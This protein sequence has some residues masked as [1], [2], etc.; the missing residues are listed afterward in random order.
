MGCTLNYRFWNKTAL[1]VGTTNFEIENDYLS[2]I[3]NQDFS[4]NLLLDF[5]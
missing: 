5:F 3:T 1:M 4:N 2:A